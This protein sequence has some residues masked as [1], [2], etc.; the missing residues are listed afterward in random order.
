MAPPVSLAVTIQTLIKVPPGSLQ[1]RGMRE[2][3]RTDDC[4][5]KGSALNSG[6][7]FSLPPGNRRDIGSQLQGDVDGGIRESDPL[8]VVR[9]GSTGHAAEGRAGK[10]REQ[11]THHGTRTLPDTVSSSLLAMGI[12][13][14][15]HVPA[16]VP[17]ARFPEEPGAVIPH[18]GICEGAPGDRCPYLNRSRTQSQL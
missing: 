6:D 11:S 3:K 9:D 17:C 2:E 12:G 5:S 8:I 14:W 7:P 18:A 15:H 10:Q 4:S 13:V 1:D 16:L